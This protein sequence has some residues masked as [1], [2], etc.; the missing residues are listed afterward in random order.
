MKINR[1]QLKNFRS[2][3]SLDLHFSAN[4]FIVFS[5]QNGSGK[6]NILEAIYLLATTK[7][8]RGARN[9]GLVKEGA[10]SYFIQSEI[11]DNMSD[12]H[13][14]SVGFSLQFGKKLT[15]DQNEIEK[16]KDFYGSFLGVVFSPGDL[17]LIDGTP[18]L[19]RKFV[20][21]ILSK[22]SNHSYLNSLISFNHTL[23]QRNALLKNFANHKD[24]NS[25]HV[26]D[27][28][29]AESAYQ[30]IKARFV[31]VD[32]II[33][34]FRD[35]Y[36]AISLQNESVTIKYISNWLLSNCD[37]DNENQCKDMFLSILEQNFEIDIRNGNTQFGPHKDDYALFLNQKPA[38]FS[39]S[40]GQKRT[41]VLCLKLSEY[42]FLRNNRNEEPILLIDDVLTE[43]DAYRK[44]FFF[45]ILRNKG[46]CLITTTHFENIQGSWKSMN[47]QVDLFEV[48]KI[49]QGSQANQVIEV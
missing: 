22:S 20:D 3:Q 11:V 28:L 10:D 31:F 23:K 2:Y 45:E 13:K 4:P 1:L 49:L 37:I 38:Q 29:L 9:S 7:S 25:L 15:F 26:W 19:R 17:Q 39:T 5:G 46:Q 35:F 24:K 21:N 14:I 40:Q 47:H 44:D 30:L 27:R 8:F 42:S 12:S 16:V 18:A 43:L 34:Y 36:N 33:D 32:K 48:R 41:M 6:T